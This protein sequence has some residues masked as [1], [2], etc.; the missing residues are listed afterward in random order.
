VGHFNMC[1]FPFTFL[2]PTPA[3][4]LNIAAFGPS[5]SVDVLHWVPTA[6][7]GAGDYEVVN[8]LVA[9]ESYWIRLNGPAT[10]QF[11]DLVGATPI[12]IPGS[13]LGPAPGTF[14][15]PLRP[16]WNQVGNPSPYAVP[17]QQLR[18]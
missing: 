14:T 12:D 18:F 2:D 5:A 15:I 6:N 9:G 3:V 17:L 1:T 8:A 4:A 7:G 10:D 13:G 11:V 16:G